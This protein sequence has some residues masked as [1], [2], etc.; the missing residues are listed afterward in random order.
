MYK[1][2]VCDG[3]ERDGF[4]VNLLDIDY[5]KVS[6]CL[7]EVEEKRM[8]YCNIKNSPIYYYVTEGEGVFYIKENEISVK[9]DDLIEIPENQKYTYIGKMKMLKMIPNGYDILEVEE[10]KI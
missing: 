5:K 6:I 9:K 8:T 3:F 7:V 1:K 2:K 4:K 10:D